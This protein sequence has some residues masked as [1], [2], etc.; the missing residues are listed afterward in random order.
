MAIGSHQDKPNKIRPKNSLRLKK[1]RNKFFKLD[2]AVCFLLC[3]LAS[4]IGNSFIRFTV[5]VVFPLKNHLVIAVGLIKTY[6]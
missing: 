2:C 6:Q 4:H 3:L 5:L 1:T